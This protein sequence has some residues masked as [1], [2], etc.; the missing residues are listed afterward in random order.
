MPYSTGEITYFDLAKRTAGGKVRLDL[1]T[2]EFVT[3]TTILGVLPV[4]EAT[5]KEKD[6]GTFLDGWE[7]NKHTQLTD[8]DHGPKPTKHDSY[9]REDVMSYR[10]AAI[11]TRKKHMDYGGAEMAALL[12]QETSLKIRDL[13]LDNEHDIFYGDPRNDER[14]MLGLYPRFWCLTDMK[15]VI[16]AGS[17]A[18][19]LSPYRTFS[20]GG[21]SDGNLSSIFLVV[22]SSR[23]GACIITPK[24]SLSGGMKYEMGTWEGGEDE[25]GGYI[26]SRTDLFSVQN[27]LSIRNRQGVVRIANIDY[28]TDAGIKG[29]VDVLYQAV[30]SVP[31][32]MRGRLMVFCNDEAIPVLSHYFNSQKYPTTANGALPEGIGGDFSIPG[33]GRFYGTVHIT[34]G[35]E[36]V[37]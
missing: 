10:D 11:V 4:V 7:Y 29:L 15:G 1:M 13:S 12:T 26:K 8:L 17:H 35:E 20:A 19:K 6:T 36:A 23:D 21:T 9:A 14:E 24:G 34:K 25:K 2:E 28:S 37:E 3:P 16:K 5:E 18:G 27:G 33:L 22:P 30:Y 31:A 32:Y